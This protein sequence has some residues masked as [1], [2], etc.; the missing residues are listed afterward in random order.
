MFKVIKS[1][2]PEIVIGGIILYFDIKWFLFYAF[3][4]ILFYLVRNI[5]HL[6]KLIRFYNLT[7]EVKIISIQRKL[8]ITPEEAKKVLE[9]QKKI[10]WYRKLA[11]F[12]KRFRRS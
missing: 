3:V 5:D 10:D 9:D 1:Y 8:G 6:R 12:R 11:I 2:I 4:V 7:T